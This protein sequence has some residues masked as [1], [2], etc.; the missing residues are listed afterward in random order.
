MDVKLVPQRLRDLK[1]LSYCP[2]SAFRGPPPSATSTKVGRNRQSIFA[3]MRRLLPKCV[4]LCRKM[5]ISANYV[6]LWRHESILV[7][8]RRN[9]SKNVD[10]RAILVDLCRF[11]SIFVDIRRFVASIYVD[12]CR[13]LSMSVE[14]ADGGGP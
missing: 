6:V 12:L 2:F 8:L 14:V 10:F 13:V 1:G 3:D 7:D 5:S 4:D 11:L 9:L